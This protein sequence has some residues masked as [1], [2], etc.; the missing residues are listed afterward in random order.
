MKMTPHYFTFILN[1][2]RERVIET[3]SVISSGMVPKSAAREYGV[4]AKTLRRHWDGKFHTPGRCLGRF[5]PD[6][7]EYDN[8]L[9]E[10]IR[11]MER[12]LFG[13]TPMDVRRL[14]VD[15]SEKLEVKHRF[16][17]NSKR[18]GKAW[19]RGFLE[20][21]PQVSIRKSEVTSLARA[22]GFNRGQVNFVFDV[23]KDILT[24]HDYSPTRVWNMDEIGITNVQIPSMIIASNGATDVG[25]LHIRLW[26]WLV[27]F[28]GHFC[29]HSR[30]NGP[31]DLQR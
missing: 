15:F 4:P 8:F 19:L 7:E 27:L 9:V 30:L 13:L 20:K 31:S 18:A 25:H 24:V 1:Y 2:G 17:K 26:W 23:Y 12:A 5:K 28:Y 21:H 14:A 6:L 10:L 16:N 22:I 11:T 29:A 3:L